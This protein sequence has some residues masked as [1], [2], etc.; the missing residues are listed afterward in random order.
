[1]PLKKL[2]GFI[3]RFSPRHMLPVF[4]LIAIFYVGA[5]ALPSAVTGI[6][7]FLLGEKT[8]VTAVI[9]TLNGEYE[10]MLGFDGS[11]PKNKGSY[12]SVHTIPQ[13]IC[14]LSSNPACP[15]QTWI[16]SPVA[17]ILKTSKP[18]GS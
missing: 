8:D 17:I 1:M 3:K 7:R 9:R 4:F 11:F 10:N 12:M 2:R 14:F 15:W 13:N 18:W 5:A 16:K 6:G